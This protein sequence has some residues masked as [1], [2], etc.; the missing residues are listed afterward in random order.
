MADLPY[1]QFFPSD[2]MGDCQILTLA[3]R[4]AWQTIICKAW[5]PSTRGVVTL[6]LSAWARLFGATVEQAE[7]VIAEIEET[8]IADIE[9]DGD[10]IT[11]ICRRIV[12]DWQAAEKRKEALSNAGAEGAKKRWGGH[13][14]A[15]RVAIQRPMAIQNPEAR[16]HKY[17]DKESAR[18]RTLDEA[19][20]FAATKQGYSPDVVR[21]WY[22]SRDGQ[23]WMKGNHL[24][25]TNWRSDLD[26]WVMNEA[27]NGHS[28]AGNAS[29]ASRDA[30]KT[31][32]AT[33]HVLPRL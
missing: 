18:P 19:L 9:R 5:H 27:R 13:G 31:G 3:A 7:K 17:K 12:R 10:A 6:K 22:A 32:L 25:I 14:Q 11:V 29:E 4:G 15:N 23:G 28:R 20:E 33:K 24:P 21:S 8:Q 16:S 26:A 2:W 30:K 1:M